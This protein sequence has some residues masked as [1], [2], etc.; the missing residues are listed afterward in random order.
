MDD[1]SSVI[2][3]VVPGDSAAAAE[4]NDNTIQENDPMGD[5]EDEINKQME[6][7]E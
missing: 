4:S 2:A 5:V 7:V 1:D 6:G 3:P